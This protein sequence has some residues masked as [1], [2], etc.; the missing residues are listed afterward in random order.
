MSG[1]I[2]LNL[3]TSEFFDTY[4]DSEFWQENAKSKLI[5]MLVNTCK[6]AEDYK[7]SR[8]NNRNKIS[9]SH[10]AIC[11]SGSRGAGKTVFLRNTESIWKK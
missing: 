4:I 10:N 7:K 5:E 2:I 6:D 11:I 8:I 1:P 3:E 9:T